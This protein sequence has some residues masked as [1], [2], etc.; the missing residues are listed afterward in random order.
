MSDGSQEDGLNEEDLE[1]LG[2]QSEDFAESD[3]PPGMNLG[4]MLILF[5]NVGFS[6]GQEEDENANKRNIL[7]RGDVLRHAK[8]QTT[9]AHNE[10]SEEDLPEETE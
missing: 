6:L 2:I 8:P 3:A 4:T 5:N 10:R 7:K 9:N 1:A